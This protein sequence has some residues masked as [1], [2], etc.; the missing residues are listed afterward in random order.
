MLVCVS[1]CAYA[2]TLCY[3]THLSHTLKHACVCVCVCTR[4]CLCEHSLRHRIAEHAPERVRNVL[5]GW[6]EVVWLLCTYTLCP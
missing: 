1:A 2:S 4:V 5:D 6:R 3:R